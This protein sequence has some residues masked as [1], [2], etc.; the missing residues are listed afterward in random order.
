MAMTKKD[1]ELIAGAI[2]VQ[3]NEHRAKGNK[4][5]VQAIMGLTSY[6]AGRL[7]GENPRFDTQ[8]FIEACGFMVVEA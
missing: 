2:R 8:R 1:Y 3:V 7:Q 6:L 5:E 4:D